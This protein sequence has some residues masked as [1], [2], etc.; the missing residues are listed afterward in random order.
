MQTQQQQLI[1]QQ[2]KQVN[3]ILD[4]YVGVDKNLDNE[5]IKSRRWFEKERE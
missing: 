1:R 4:K 2:E 3:F 5:V